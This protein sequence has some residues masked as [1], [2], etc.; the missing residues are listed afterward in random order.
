MNWQNNQFML[1]LFHCKIDIA[2]VCTLISNHRKSQ[3]VL[4]YLFSVRPT[5]NR[6]YKKY[7]LHLERKGLNATETIGPRRKVVVPDE[8]YPNMLVEC[9]K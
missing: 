2:A 1:H 3:F 9:K 4:V 8:K 7:T 5:A 6:K